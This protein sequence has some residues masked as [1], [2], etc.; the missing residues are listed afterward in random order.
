VKFNIDQYM[1]V[2]MITK[3]TIYISIQEIVDTH[4][5]CTWG[6]YGGGDQFERLG[7]TMLLPMIAQSV[8]DRMANLR[9]GGSSLTVCGKFSV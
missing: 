6:L 2:T 7:L 5:V 4:Q 8:E 3:P 1:D 9:I